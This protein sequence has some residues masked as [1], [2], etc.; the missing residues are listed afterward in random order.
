M[1][2]FDGHLDLSMCAIHWNRD[3]TRPLEEVRRREKHLTDKPDRGRGV[4]T[5]PEM[6]RG[7]VGVCI[8]TQIG[9]SV[10]ETS[11]VQGWHSPEIAWA[12]TQAQL[13]WYQVMEEYGE[14]KQIRDRATLLA[15][16]AL[17][18]NATPEE[19]QKLP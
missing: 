13:A 10:S 9:H 11:P 1:L 19:Q 7:Q 18:K 6:R 14:M 12:Q 16:V 15:H 3:L 4:L 2:I 17:W 8:A 5:F